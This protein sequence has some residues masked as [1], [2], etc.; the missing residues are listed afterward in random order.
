MQQTRAA[1]VSHTITVKKKV[2]NLKMEKNK[3]DS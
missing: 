1:T 2:N 3:W